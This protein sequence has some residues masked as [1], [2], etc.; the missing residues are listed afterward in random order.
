MNEQQNH[1]INRRDVI[2]SL[3]TIPVVGAFL[4]SAS[5]KSRH[6]ATIKNDIL[7]E[8]N[9]EPSVPPATGP[10]SGDPV[11]IGIIGY[12]IRGEQLLRALGFAS[13]AWIENMKQNALENPKDTRLK[14][15]LEQE[16]LNVQITAVSDAFDVRRETAVAAGTRDGVTPKAYRTYQ[17]LLEDPNVDAVVIAT[18]DHLHA[19]ISM[20]ALRAGKHV[21]VEKCMTHKIGET[22]EL[23]DT[24][25]STGKVFQ[26]GH[27]HRQTQSFFTARDIISKNV[28]GHISL[29]QTNTNR[30]SDNLMQRT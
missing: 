12:G 19:P 6:D 16:N 4:M 28:L 1:K 9:V 5:A 11:R 14:D 2:M 15:F 7:R 21:Y 26:V 27:Q 8:L 30:N 17:E 24:V 10:M 25:K 13:P 29:I 22:Y 3:A 20:Q 23:Y 18:P